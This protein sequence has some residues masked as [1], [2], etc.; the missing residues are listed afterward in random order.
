M[1][2][3]VAVLLA[4]H[5]LIHAMGF[6]KAFGF[7]QLTQLTQPISRPVGVAWGLATVAMLLASVTFITTPR[8]FWVVGAVALVLS[9]VVIVLAWKDAKF[10]TLP[11]VVLLVAVILRFAAYGPTSM[12]AEYDDAVRAELRNPAPAGV[13]TEEDLLSLPAPVA[14]YLRVTGAV[15]QPRVFNFRAKWRGRMRG[16]A[17]EPWMEFEAEQY[18]FYA[19]EPSRIFFMSASKSGVPVDVFHRF[20]GE[21]AT[22]RVRLLSLLTMVDAKGPEMNRA[23]TVTL[24][25]DMCLLAPATLLSPSIRWEPVDA[26]RARAHYTRRAETIAAE[27]VFDEA[28]DLVDFSSDDRSAASADGK[29][30]TRQRWTTPVRNYRAFGARRVGTF[31]ETRW[32]APTG[33][34]T[35]GEFE[36]QSIEYNV[37]GESP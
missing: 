13:V 37:R 23:E 1:R 19:A 16:A 20:V 8:W 11:N 18:N 36:L 9:Q 27:L 3:V 26:R 31:G 2:W 29:T 10:G 22:F 34:F 32:D 5:A 14:N 6:L 4:V 28:G 7:A 17:S 21:P 35:Y 24:F 25:N 12:R 15:G 33:T 30:F